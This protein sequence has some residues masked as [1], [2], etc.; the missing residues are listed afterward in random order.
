MN[1]IRT[2][3]KEYVNGKKLSNSKVDGEISGN[4]VEFANGMIIVS[5][6]FNTEKVEKK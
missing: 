3:F 4:K 1:A 2:E 6:P 5:K